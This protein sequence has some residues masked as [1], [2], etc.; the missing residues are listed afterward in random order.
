MQMPG[1]ANISPIILNPAGSQ[2]R[3]VLRPF[4]LL[5]TRQREPAGPSTT[6]KFPIPIDVGFPPQPPAVRHQPLPV[7]RLKQSA[8]A[9]H[10]PRLAAAT[11]GDVDPTLAEVKKRPQLPAAGLR[12]SLQV[13]G[14]S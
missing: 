5:R 8:P 3:K 11:T 2:R 1:L 10:A 7:T 4:C 9:L 12:P 14:W 6:R 13:S